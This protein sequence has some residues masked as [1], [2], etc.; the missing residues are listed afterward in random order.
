MHSKNFDVIY[1]SLWWIINQYLLV[2]EDE[3]QTQTSAYIWAKGNEYTTTSGYLQL[4]AGNVGSAP[5]T[6]SIWW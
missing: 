4:N 5:I 3:N 1:T 2:V 6:F